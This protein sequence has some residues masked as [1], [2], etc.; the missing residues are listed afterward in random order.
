MKNPHLGP[1]YGAF[2]V[3]FNGKEYQYFVC[4]E[5]CF[6]LVPCLYY[7]VLKVLS[8]SEAHFVFSNLSERCLALLIIGI[9]I[10]KHPFIDC[11]F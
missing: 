9:D 11:E 2:N 4:L 6:V 1:C 8:F 10:L 7:Y 5:C 3:Q